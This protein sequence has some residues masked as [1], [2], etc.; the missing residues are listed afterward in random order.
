MSAI[1]TLPPAAAG[2]AVG[3]GAPGVLGRCLLL[4]L[5]SLLA[6]SAVLALIWPRLEMVG[7][8]AG[9]S[10]SLLSLP[11]VHHHRGPEN[12]L[13]V[14]LTAHW[15]TPHRWQVIPDDNLRSI[16]INGQYVPLDKV[17]PGG[18][19]DYTHGF[20]ID[21]GPWLSSGTNEILF[22]VD[23]GGGPGGLDFRPVPG[24]L[25]WS[26]TGAA[27]LPLLIG[28][29]GLF[30]LRTSQ[31]LILVL[32]LVLLCSYWSVTP[33]QIRAYD[34]GYDGGHVG[35]VMW[36]AHNLALPNPT[37]GWIYYHPPL[38]YL[39]G[40]AIWGWAQWLGLPPPVTLQALSLALWLVFLTASAG[41]L[42]LMLP[43]RSGLLALAT[44]GL[45]LWPSGII[46]AV[47][48]AN[49]VPLYAISGVATW[50]MV[51]WWQRRRRSDLWGMA[52]ACAL[53]M[54]TKSNGIV[55]VAAC[56][57]LVAGTLLHRRG[58]QRALASLAIFA[59][60]TFT[61]LVA[62][63]AVRI[64]Y[65]LQGAISNW[66]VS[67][68]SSL[69]SQLRAPL[70]LKFFLPLDIPTFLTSPWMDTR[71]DTTGRANFWNFMLRSALSG[72]FHFP[73]TLQRVVAFA[74]GALLLALFG[75]SLLAPLRDTSGRTLYRYRPWILLAFFWVASLMAYRYTQSYACVADFRFILPVLVPAVLY[76]VLAGRLTRWLLFGICA[77]S[78]LFF[79]S[80]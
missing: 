7:T 17:R 16:R 25:G 42:R 48:I 61:G 72:E 32:A 75:A 26:L 65:Y 40:A 62:S 24:L 79:L 45:A 67:N 73:G 30:R 22:T 52:I 64:Y 66:M 38:Y 43:Q 31:T 13:A 27:F 1:P 41:S 56:G 5:A 46:H 33:W 9:Q 15:L 28:L 63:F 19:R 51:R 35:Y 10:K 54:L 69:D 80:I 55:L 50:H 47:R 3:K 6:V 70:G 78:A 36:V 57:L 77:T 34:V 53:A 14:R 23:N 8:A 44:L 59:C 74:W 12:Q 39:L 68:V 37:E 18:L 2:T 76:W 58:R 4:A 11:W 29:A 71:D 21:L 60:V 49:D 20:F